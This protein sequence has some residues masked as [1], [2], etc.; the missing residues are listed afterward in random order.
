MKLR[1]LL[2]VAFILSALFL[3]HCGDDDDDDDADDDDA[4]D[5]DDSGRAA[6]YIRS[7]HYDRLVIEVDFE[8]GLTPRQAALD[9]AAARLSEILDKPGGVEFVID[10]QILTERDGDEWDNATLKKC[11][12]DSY[13]MDAADGVIKM[14]VIYVHGAYQTDGEGKIL[15][16][17]WDN[18]HAAL[19]MDGIEDT[20]ATFGL[21]DALCEKAELWVLTH[22]IGHV[23]GLVNNGVPMLTDHEDPDHP[24]HDI[25]DQ[26]IM[27]WA[28]VGDSLLD[29][30]LQRILGGDDSDIGFG[31]DCLNDIAAVRDGAS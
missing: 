27:Y 24:H 12:D 13:D 1:K 11:A 25:S 23:L 6:D 7:D 20:C 2:L 9:A 29:I 30:L 10:E 16:L 22:E 31:Q 8:G 4:G 19:F 21:G 18:L 5:D 15:G 14:H 3:T 17:A 26:C 28:Y